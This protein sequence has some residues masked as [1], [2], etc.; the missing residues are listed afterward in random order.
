MLFKFSV[1]GS[2][3]AQ[4][5]YHDLGLLLERIFVEV[6][7]LLALSALSAL[8]WL[9]WQLVRAKRFTRFKR[10]LDQDIKPKVVSHILDE[11]EQTRS[12]LFP[13]NQVHQDATVY[14]WGSVPVS[15]CLY[16]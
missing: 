3:P 6:L 7:V 9:V 13:N 11:L 5:W 14:Y 2:F 15:C 16:L 10:T 8:L 12:D 1:L 4:D